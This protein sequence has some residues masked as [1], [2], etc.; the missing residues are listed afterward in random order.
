MRLALARIGARYGPN[1]AAAF[2]RAADLTRFE[3]VLG[4]IA[5]VN[6]RFTWR[7]KMGGQPDFLFPQWIV[8]FETTHDGRRMCHALT[9]EPIDGRL[10]SLT[11]HP[12][13]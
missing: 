12:C 5:N 6:S 7:A 10:T 3:P 13:R 9:F 11:T 4:A 2:L 1:E 8:T